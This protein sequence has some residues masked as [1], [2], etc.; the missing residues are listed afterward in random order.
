MLDDITNMRLKFNNKTYNLAPQLYV[1]DLLK[2]SRYVIQDKDDIRIRQAKT[3]K[4]F[5]SNFSIEHEQNAFIVFVNHQQV[6][7]RS[8]EHTSELQS[9]G[10]LVCRL[11][12]EKKNLLTIDKI[13]KHVHPRLLQYPIISSVH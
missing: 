8:E 12:L 10:H 7:L 1:N 11:L 13:S 3:I 2:G 4:D 5:F 6:E 9:R